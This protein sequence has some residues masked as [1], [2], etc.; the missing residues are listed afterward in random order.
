M[1]AKQK[2]VKINMCYCYYMLIYNFYLFSYNISLIYYSINI[3]GQSDE[4][5]SSHY[6]SVTIIIIMNEP[7]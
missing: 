1:K 7:E 5:T 4:K 6:V 2:K 3:N